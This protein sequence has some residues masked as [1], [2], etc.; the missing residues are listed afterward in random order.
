[1]TRQLS[2]LQAVELGVVVVLGLAVAAWVLLSID[3]RH[4]LGGDAITVEAGFDDIDGAEVGTRVRLQ[5]ID[6][7]QVVAVVP[8]AL[9]RG[10]V[11]LRMRLAGKVRHL[12]TSDSRVQI[13]GESMFAGRIVN[14]LPG[15][16]DA[17]PITEGAC[18]TGIPAVKL[19]DEIAREVK[20]TVA[21]ELAQVN[22]AVDEIG[23]LVKDFRRGEGTAGTTAVE[24]NKAMVKVNTLLDDVN[25]GKGTLGMLAKDPAAYHEL[26]GIL[27]SLKQNADALK[28]LPVVRSFV[29]D[30]AK[31]LIRP[32]CKCD[33]KWFPEDALFTPGRAVLTA[34]GRKRL[35]EAAVWLNDH[36]EPG[37]EIVVAAFAAPGQNAEV[38]Q[39]LTQKQSEVV[40]EYLRKTHL[41]NK[42][43]WL[44]WWSTRPVRA[45]GVGSNPP[46]L[47]GAEKLPPARLEL[48]VFT[49]E[50]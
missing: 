21:Q 19:T 12:V 9:P 6:V 14:I 2:R 20:S 47:P 23:G 1:M 38:A 50:K 32:D 37:S 41:V 16:A 46:P 35:D 26:L 17:A 36:K 31:E 7:G 40:S 24:L 10:E 25:D 49:P 15:S 8:P 29:V 22:G 4:G 3:Q 39:N 44:P 34:E 43:G 30:P 11:K 28:S 18:L 33:R 13:A 5:G 45:L 27:I 48:L 42:T